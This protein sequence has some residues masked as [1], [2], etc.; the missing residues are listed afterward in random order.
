MKLLIIA[1]QGYGNPRRGIEHVPPGSTVEVGNDLAVR[2]IESHIAVP[3]P[4]PKREAHV[5]APPEN[6]AKSVSKPKP[7]ARAKEEDGAGKAE[8]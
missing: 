2:L 3:A 4:A 8:A 6:T 7:K 5:V 1:A